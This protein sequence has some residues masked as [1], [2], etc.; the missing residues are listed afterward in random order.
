MKEKT[1]TEYYLNLA[2]KNRSKHLIILKDEKEFLSS[3]SYKYELDF[4]FEEN[5]V[6]IFPC[7]SK[8]V[9]L[10][11]YEFKLCNG[12]VSWNEFEQYYALLPDD[13]IKY[14]NSYVEENYRNSLLK[15]A[16]EEENDS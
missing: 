1:I 2:K 11:G 14:I 8:S 3:N 5:C 13:L 4:Q 10:I 16:N 6:L 9:E 7:I 12:R 15:I